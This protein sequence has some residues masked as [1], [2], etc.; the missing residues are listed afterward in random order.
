MTDPKIEADRLLIVEA[1]RKGTA[2][3]LRAYTRLSGPGWLQSAITLGGG[4]LAGSL[5]LGVIGGYE[6]MWLQP[7]MMIFGVIM[8]SA[9]AYVTLSTEMRPFHAI[10]QHV[11]PVLG[12]GW[13]LAAMLANLVW[14]MPQ[15]SLGFSAMD[16]N[17]LPGTFGGDNGKYLGVAILFLIAA[18]IV[19]FYDSGGWGIKL[20][21]IVLK[22]MVAVI[23]VSFFAVVAAMTLKG[24]L[25]WGRIAGGFIP[26]FSMLYAPHDSFAQALAQSAHDEYWRAVILETQQDLMITAAATAVGINMTFLLPYSMLRKGWNK[27][28][29]GLA[30]FDLSTG[31]FIPFVLATSCVVIASAAQFHGSYEKWLVGEEAK[32]AFTDE[33]QKVYGKIEKDFHKRL[34]G[35]ASS[36]AKQSRG[37]A[38]GTMDEPQRAAAVEQQKAALTAGDRQIAA[39]LVKR[40]AGILALSLENLTGKGVAQYVFGI[41]VVGMAVSTII[42]LML[43]NG[44]CLTEMLNTPGNKVVH[45]IGAVMPGLSGAA[46]FLY[47]WGNEQANFWLAVPTSRFGMILLPVAYITFFFMMNNRS[48]LGDQ[49]PRGGKRLALNALMLTAIAVATV[50]SALAIWN[51]KQIIPGTTIIFRWVALGAVG[52]FVVLAA[53]A[54]VMRAGRATR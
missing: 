49:V 12:W 10:N 23:V 25:P 15:F 31:L 32:P 33:Q 21:E 40:D 42:I 1:R 44:F 22:L 13:L 29:R 19:W 2:A 51:S 43:I 11:N 18:V 3:K 35:A 36:W 45:R 24:H 54:H 34:D 50:G 4:S 41:G 28:F 37:E 5:Y 27:D 46:G 52:V 14:A 17:L 6:I 7:L 53:A 38:W 8:L 30:T 9:I 16:Q 39:M 47:L 48:L 20:F 26:D